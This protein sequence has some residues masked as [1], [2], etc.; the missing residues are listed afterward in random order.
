MLHSATSAATYVQLTLVE[1]FALLMNGRR[2]SMPH[3]A[4]RVLTYL[5]LVNRPVARA[6]LAGALWPDCTDHRAS[7]CLRTALWRL[8][9]VDS[10][11]V[12]IRGERLC[13]DPKVVV[14]ISRLNDVAQRLVLAP[15]GESL[16]QVHLLIDHVELLP[17]WDE[18]WVAVNRERYRLGRL[19]ALESAACA[20]L[21]RGQPGPAL[22]AASAVVE[23]EP[24]R[25]SAR[26]IVMRG[27]MAQGN[28]IEAIQE[29]RRYRRLVRSEFGVDPSAAMEE[30]LS[31]C[32]RQ[33]CR[34][35]DDAVALRR[36]RQRTLEV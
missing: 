26:R 10:D 23:T 36:R 15:D 11:L 25:E 22:I 17:D 20:L 1:E 35:S 24:L 8:R 29:H 31:A 5:A 19:A 7:K 14:D 9:Q 34:L 30:L 13:L 6:R 18:E 4:E 28:T 16:G 27:H 33:Q 21:D 12:E 2:L 3:I 32:Y